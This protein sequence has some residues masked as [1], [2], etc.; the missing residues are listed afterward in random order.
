[1][2]RKGGRRRREKGIST[3]REKGGDYHECTSND[4]NFTHKI[5]YTSDGTDQA[6]YWYYLGDLKKDFLLLPPTHPCIIF[7]A[8]I[9]SFDSPREMLYGT[10]LCCTVRHC[11]CRGHLSST[12]SSSF[13][14]L[15]GGGS[16]NSR[17]R[18]HRYSHSQK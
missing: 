15:G 10:V 5:R 17:H 4:D 13:T 7:L 6:Y 9:D 12:V 1:M 14:P 2:G 3:G 18:R 8:T 16:N 11:T